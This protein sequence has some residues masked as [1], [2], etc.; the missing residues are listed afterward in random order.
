MET[1]W[2]LVIFTTLAGAGA[3]MFFSFCVSALKGD[4][5]NDRTKLISCVVTL[6]LLIV[7]GLA[8]VTHLSHPD[9]IMAVLAHPTMGIF[10]EAL[11]VGLVCLTVAAYL[12]AWKR[13]ASAAVQKGIL[14]C[15]AVLSVLL[16]L[17][18]GYSYM[19][20]AR[21]MWDTILLPLAYML[22]SASS[23][24]AA[25]VVVA[26][27]GKESSGALSFGSKLLVGAGA[28]AAVSALA[29]GGVAGAL[30]ASTAAFWLT[31]VLCAAA[32]PA[33]VGF[34]VARKPSQALGLGVAA[35]MFGLVGCAAFR[36]L[37]WT[38][39]EGVRNYFGLII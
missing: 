36:C 37:M 38:V 3:W 9:R 4:V 29:Y 23:G 16:A 26:A 25:Y 24:C 18:L 11:F 27:I 30:D 32:L 12:F 17:M 22:T 31:I 13:E 15:G 1:Q 28:L 5:E 2:S 7:G 6:A 33:V 19:M 8:S 34:I 39:G 14:V 21:P 20:P 35:L 10:A